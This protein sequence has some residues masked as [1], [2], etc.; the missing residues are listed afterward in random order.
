VPVKGF[1]FAGDLATELAGGA[2]TA[3]QAL[4]LLD[5]ML[6]VRELEEMIV[7]MRS[8]GGYEPLPGYDYRG[9]THVSIGQEGAAVGASS[10]LRADDSITSSHRGHGDASAKG[11]SALP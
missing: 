2:L 10:A 4:D 7:R 6:A 11:I 3:G 9:P 8:G 5:D 1:T